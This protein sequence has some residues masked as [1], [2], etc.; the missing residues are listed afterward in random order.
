MALTPSAM[1][2]Y[3]PVCLS[4]R[5]TLIR[6]VDRNAFLTPIVPKTGLVLGIGVWIHVRELAEQTPTVPSLI[7]SPCVLVDRVMLETRL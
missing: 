3:V 2:V 6:A 1:K 5:E 7:T 4:T